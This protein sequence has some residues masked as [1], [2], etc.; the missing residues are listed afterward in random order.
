M[1]YDFGP[2][3]HTKYTKVCVTYNNG[4]Y[5]VFIDGAKATPTTPIVDVKMP[6]N[7]QVA[8]TLGY[9]KNWPAFRGYIDDFCFW[10]SV[11]SHEDIMKCF[12]KG[13]SA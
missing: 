4:V 8:T 13:R 1:D 6:P 11:Q 2:A 7:S 9:V 12:D 5:E 10:I 3:D